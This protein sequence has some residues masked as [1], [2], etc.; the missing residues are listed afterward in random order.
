ML[1][2]MPEDLNLVVSKQDDGLLL[3]SVASNKNDR[4]ISH[5]IQPMGGVR[6]RELR[7]AT[8]AQSCA[9]ARRRRRMA[10]TWKILSFG[11]ERRRWRGFQ[12][13]C[14]ILSI[15]ISPQFP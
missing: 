12:P 10:L 15:S 9:Q 11:T 14:T 7:A 13:D 3:A 5:D 2:K 4:Q 6:E 8:S 1:T